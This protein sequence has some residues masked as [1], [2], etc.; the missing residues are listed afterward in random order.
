MRNLVDHLLQYRDFKKLL[1]H[2]SLSSLQQKQIKTEHIPTR[3]F[4]HKHTHTRETPPWPPYQG[5]II[6]NNREPTTPPG[7]KHT[8]FSLT[9]PWLLPQS[10][11][12]DGPTAGQDQR[13]P[14]AEI[15]WL[16]PPSGVNWQDR[17]LPNKHQA[18][19]IPLEKR[20]LRI[21]KTLHQQMTLPTTIKWYLPPSGVNWII[22]VTAVRHSGGSCS[23]VT[24]FL[25]LHMWLV[26]PWE[27]GMW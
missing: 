17:T 9:P 18:A 16:L 5:S 23:L 13:T 27:V 4:R 12:P 21:N 20:L 7:K 3:N 8:Q 14:R 10:E 22:S 2:A 6:F 1:Y 24:F 15:K 19:P 11:P 26:P 25:A